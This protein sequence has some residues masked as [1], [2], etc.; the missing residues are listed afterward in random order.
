MLLVDRQKTHIN[1]LF[2][3][4]YI[5]FEFIFKKEKQKTLTIDSM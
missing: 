5:N 1:V 4:N 3:E 2:Q